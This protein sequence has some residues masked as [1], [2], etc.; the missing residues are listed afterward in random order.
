MMRQENRNTR[1]WLPLAMLAAALAVALPAAAQVSTG[2]IEVLTVDQQGL[3]M[4]GVT[5][6]VRNTDTGNDRVGVADEFGRAVF[7]ALPP[8][9]GFHAG[10]PTSL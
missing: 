9:P 6:L 2:T 8:G 10:F 1:S 4:P 3:A 5:V 7:P